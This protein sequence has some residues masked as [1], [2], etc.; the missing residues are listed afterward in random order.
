MP[1]GVVLLPSVVTFE[2][3]FPV[4]V[5]FAIAP[6]RLIPRGVPPVVAVELMPVTLFPDTVLF[7]APAIA[8]PHIVTLAA[9][10][11]RPEM[12]LFETVV[13]GEKLPIA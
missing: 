9:E 1:V 11:V 3:V 10:L 8:I 4:T 12:V 13:F 2:T 5:Q 7:D 6:C